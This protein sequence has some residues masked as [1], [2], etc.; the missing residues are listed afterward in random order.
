MTDAAV[1]V[2][3]GRTWAGWVK[4]LD[5]AD[6]HAMKH[7]EIAKLLVSTYASVSPWWA[8]SITVGYE[9]IRG[10]REVQQQRDSTFQAS[11]SRTFCVD[12]TTLFAAFKDPRRRKKWM[13]TG[14]KRIRVS[15]E[16]RS[17]RVDWDDG[18]Q[19]NVH[20]TAKGP[21]KSSVSVQHVKLNSAA[22]VAT[23]KTSWTERFDALRDL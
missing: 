21:G 6:A 3:T 17:M 1:K 11:K 10:L 15:T 23:A 13:G 7:S 12:I 8:Q 9:R 16:D 22:D 18:T 5:A 4:V 14:W 2:K 19:V 20:F